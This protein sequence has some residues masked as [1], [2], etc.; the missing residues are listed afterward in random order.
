METVAVALFLPLL[1]VVRWRVRIVALPTL[2]Q[3]GAV[4]FLDL[5]RLVAL[6]DLFRLIG[7]RFLRPDRD[8]CSASP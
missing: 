5:D 4:P 2:V 8:K 7:S 3:V 1:L 6:H